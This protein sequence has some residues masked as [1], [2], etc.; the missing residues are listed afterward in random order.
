MVFNNMGWNEIV[1]IQID[2]CALGS[3]LFMRFWLRSQYKMVSLNELANGL[4]P[5]IMLLCS[6]LP[7]EVCQTPSRCSERGDSDVGDT[8]VLVA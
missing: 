3:S 8:V 5:K 7:P 1:Q 4:F 2:T 6:S